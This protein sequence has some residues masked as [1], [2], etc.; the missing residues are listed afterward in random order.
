[1]SARDEF[2]AGTR[3]LLPALVSLFPSA[4]I[5]GIIA[6]ET[7]STNPQAIWMSVRIYTGLAQAATL[8]LMNPSASTVVIVVAGVSINLRLLLYS[9][10]LAP[11]FDRQ[12]VNE[13]V[14][15]AYPNVET[16]YALSTATFETGGTDEKV[17][18]DVGA[19][20][21]SRVV[22]QSGTLVGFSS[23]A[24]FRTAAP[25]VRDST[26]VHCLARSSSHR[27][28]RDRRGRSRRRR[29]GGVRSRLPFDPG[30]IVGTLAGIVAW[31]TENLAATVAVGT[32]VFWIPRGFV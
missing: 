14:S 4:V 11:Y 10:S 17:A 23:G 1:M 5:V 32:V 2:A 30:L 18:Y 19:G 13:H 6:V 24:S 28:T 29:R 22:W 27:P 21:A 26:A 8:E 20:V 3:D 9:A 15:L 31:R 25:R 12:S 16:V 7:G